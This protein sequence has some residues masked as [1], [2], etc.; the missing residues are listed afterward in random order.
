MGVLLLG[1]WCGGFVCWGGCFGGCVGFCGLL[2]FWGLLVSCWG[3]LWCFFVGVG[4]GGWGCGLVGGLGGCVLW[5]GG[6]GCVCLV[7]VCCFF[8]VGFCWGFCCV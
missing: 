1:V 7:F 2:F 5:F 4:W 3:C 8:V 6:V